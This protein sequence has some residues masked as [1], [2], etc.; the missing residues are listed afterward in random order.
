[1]ISEPN[2]NPIPSI[3]LLQLEIESRNADV[4]EV[5][6]NIHDLLPMLPDLPDDDMEVHG[7]EAEAV[8]QNA[9]V[10]EM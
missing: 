10:E 7:A 1:M 4:A 3:S 6:Q 2:I 9:A 8:D 5:I